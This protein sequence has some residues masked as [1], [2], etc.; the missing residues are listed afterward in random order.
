M[1]VNLHNKHHLLEHQIMAMLQLIQFSSVQF[2]PSTDW[3]VGGTWRT[4][5]QG[6]SSSLFCRRP[7]WASCPSS[8]SSA[9]HG[10]VHPSKC[11]E[12]WLW[13]GCR[14]VW[15]ARIMQ[16]S[17][18]WKLPEKVARN[19]HGSWCCSAQ[20][21]VFVLLVGDTENV[22]HVLGFESLD[23]FSESASRVHVSQP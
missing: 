13:R 17:V 5:Q 4:I 6:F 1:C 11:P 22:P 2:S 3:V 20:S 12:G 21:L 10:V 9:D 18:S 8:I 16:V 19:P 15:Y 7:L 14:G 23:P